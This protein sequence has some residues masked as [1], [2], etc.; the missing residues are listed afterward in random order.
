MAEMIQINGKDAYYLVNGIMYA[1]TFPQ[2]WANH[3]IKQTGPHDCENCD[4]FGK[5]RGVFIGY[6]ANCAEYEY[7]SMR[8]YGFIDIGKEKDADLHES[9]MQTYLKNVDLKEMPYI[10]ENYIFEENSEHDYL[11]IN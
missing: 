4:W 5:W 10:D 2:E 6:C 9:A 11:E 1:P 7:H 8:G 3:H